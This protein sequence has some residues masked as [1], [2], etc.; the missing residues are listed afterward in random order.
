MFK[1]S[2]D[3]PLE[4]L[5]AGDVPADP[6]DNL[7]TDQNKLSVYEVTGDQSQIERIAAAFAAGSN[8]DKPKEFEFILFNQEILPEL[9]IRLDS[10]EPGV[11]G[12]SEVDSW[13]RDL[14]EL[15]ADKLA[16]LAKRLV[17]TAEPRIVMG[18]QVSAALEESV[19]SGKIPLKHVVNKKRRDKLQQAI[20][21]RGPRQ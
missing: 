16:S 11:T 9:A 8:D 5:Q 2:T 6:L 17:P 19:V 21:A 14:V 1:W 4:W 3:E 20:E 12:D 13:H 15:S 10:S 18:K 7:A